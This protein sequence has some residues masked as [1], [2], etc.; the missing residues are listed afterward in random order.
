[1]QTNSYKRLSLFHIH[2]ELINISIDSLIK[3][4]LNQLHLT[5]HK[6]I[7]YQ[8]SKCAIRFHK[9]KNIQEANDELI[10]TYCKGKYQQQILEFIKNNPNHLL[11][12]DNKAFRLI[13]LLLIYK[14][15]N[16][17]QGTYS[18]DK[19]STNKFSLVGSFLIANHILE[20]VNVIMKQKP[21]CSSKI[22]EYYSRIK[23]DPLSA[24]DKA[25]MYENTFWNDNFQR[26]FKMS[27]EEFNNALFET[28]I[29]LIAKEPMI[30]DTKKPFKSLPDHL[31]ERVLNL[32][33]QNCAS[34]PYQMD[35]IKNTL[36]ENLYL[37][38]QVRGKPLIKVKD[39]A[40]CF[41]PDQMENAISE[42]PFH[43][44]FTECKETNDLK[45]KKGQAFQDYVFKVTKPIF[46]D[47]SCHKINTK[48]GG[49][50]GDIII[51]ISPE[52]KI[53]IELK[54]ALVQDSLKKGSIEEL[55]K[56][57]LTPLRRKKGKGKESPGPLQVIQ[58]A[59]DYKKNFNFEGVIQPII[60]YGE[61][62]PEFECFDN[63]YNKHIKQNKIC[64]D[65]DCNPKN[66]PLILMNNS[67]WELILSAIKQQKREK[68]L[69]VLNAILASLSSD[70]NYPSKTY[71]NVKKYI[72][73]NKLRLS[74]KSLFSNK[75][76][77][78]GEKLKSKLPH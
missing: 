51:D 1:M 3:H 54:N 4:L 74:L 5:E 45:D 6:N 73:N 75:L 11:F 34:K 7:L 27:I 67:T 40:Y 18:S 20:Y 69:F 66:N 36:C 39:R 71:V 56:R 30:L 22:M 47:K 58:R 33:S 38:I 57:F 37:D 25:S 12:L 77:T 50:Y 43:L 10:K 53:I 16:L 19:I 29:H 14:I 59:L 21:I 8:I 28:Y 68:T 31:G 2:P 65:Y 78:K 48:K 44:V 64:K 72:E 63:L 60:I 26:L 70:A 41:R 55:K 15:D 9:I 62:Y 61:C 23:T 42:L 49:E 35:Q 24:I 17:E 13:H 46:P 32:L 76:I 52:K